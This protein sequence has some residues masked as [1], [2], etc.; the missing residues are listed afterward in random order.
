MKFVA[1]EVME[2]LERDENGHGQCG[3]ARRRRVY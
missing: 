3:W 2:P 1:V